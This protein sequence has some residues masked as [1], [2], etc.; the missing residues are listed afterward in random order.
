MLSQ[1]KAFRTMTT[2]DHT[3]IALASFQS[4]TSFGSS[5]QFHCNHTVEVTQRSRCAEVTQRSRRAAVFL[6]SSN[7]HAFSDT[8]FKLRLWLWR[9]KS[10]Q[11]GD[12]FR[13]GCLYQLLRHLYSANT[14]DDAPRI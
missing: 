6:L 9:K 11:T 2:P 7:R 1:K 5:P 13:L 14:H 8:Y 4:S 3:Q 12:V 10:L